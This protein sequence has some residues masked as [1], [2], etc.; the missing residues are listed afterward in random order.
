MW[1]GISITYLTTTVA[2]AKN[3]KKGKPKILIP[4]VSAIIRQPS[5]VATDRQTDKTEDIWSSFPVIVYLGL[6]YQF[7]CQ[8]P[9][10]KV[11][12]W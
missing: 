6:L 9:L 3:I 12:V 5:S 1:L 11:A 2:L 4:N 7:V 8:L 10:M